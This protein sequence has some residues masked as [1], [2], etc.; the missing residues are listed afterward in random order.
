[1][2]ADARAGLVEKAQKPRPWPP[3]S[4]LY[5]RRGGRIAQLPTGWTPRLC[6]PSGKATFGSV[7]KSEG[8]CARR[9]A[10][11]RPNSPR[12]PRLWLLQGR[13]NE[14]RTP[15]CAREASIGGFAKRRSGR[16]CQKGHAQRP[17]PANGI[18][19]S[20]APPPPATNSVGGSPKRALRFGTTQRKGAWTSGRRES[21]ECRQS[22]R[23]EWLLTPKA[24]AAARRLRLMKSRSEVHRLLKPTGGPEWRTPPRFEKHIG[25]SSGPKASREDR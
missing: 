8:A 2:R 4:S 19:P 14:P 6:F 22:S 24:E 3:R 10:G 21:F 18:P 20:K 12:H 16:K 25:D 17:M 1:M 23:R 13:T 15:A 11:R 5:Y 7:T 9:R